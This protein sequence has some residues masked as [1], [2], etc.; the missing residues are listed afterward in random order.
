LAKSC[1]TSLPDAT[2]VDLFSAVAVGPDLPDRGPIA[3]MDFFLA[4]DGQSIPDHLWTRDIFKAAA[5]VHD[6]GRVWV[7]EGKVGQ[8]DHSPVKSFNAITAPLGSPIAILPEGD[9]ITFKLYDQ[10]PDESLIAQG[11]GAPRL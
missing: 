2:F 10:S 4:R 1:V 11:E 9:L 5:Y 8:A 3:I 7:V 6:G